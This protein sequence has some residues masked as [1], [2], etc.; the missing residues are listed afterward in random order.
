MAVRQRAVSR[1]G[2]AIG[3]SGGATASGP[4]LVCNLP[5][6]AGP[7]AGAPEMPSQRRLLRLCPIKIVARGGSAV[8]KELVRPCGADQHGVV[9]EEELDGRSP[10][11]HNF[12]LVVLL[13]VFGGHDDDPP[14]RLA[15]Q[16]F[17]DFGGRA[18]GIALE[19]FL[20]LLEALDELVALVIK[21]GD[22]GIGSHPDAVLDQPGS[23]ANHG[24]RDHNDYHVFHKVFISVFST[25]FFRARW[26]V[27]GAAVL[28]RT[29][30]SAGRRL[31]SGRSPRKSLSIEL[32]A[33]TPRRNFG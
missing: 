15:G 14:L 1:S 3:D 33:A 6:R 9:G 2:S 4:A 32:I 24:D 11:I 28:A 26:A 20:V 25:G 13:A 29:I 5:Q 10:W 22:F 31:D 17:G 8:L 12:A 16:G 21:L 27:E 30:I 23:T 7:E 18:A 19:E